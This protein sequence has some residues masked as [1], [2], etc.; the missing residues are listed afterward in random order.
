MNASGT[1]VTAVA[2]ATANI[3]TNAAGTKYVSVGV[4]NAQIAKINVDT[5]TG[6]VTDA[7]TL[8][9]TLQTTIDDGFATTGGS[10]QVTNLHV[11]L[12]NKKVFANIVGANGVGTLNNF[13]LWD[14]TSITGAT[15]FAAGTSLT[16]LSGLKITAAGFT[17]FS[18]ALGLTAIGQ[19]ALA[20]VT[21][22]GTI[23]S[24]IT[25]TAVPEP[26]SYALALAGLAGVGLIARRR[27]V[28]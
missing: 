21:D 14:I 1:V 16:T 19:G 12:T 17:A 13:Y 3:V 8:G 24:S 27:R 22:F 10:L 18:N 20:G 11:D 4:T 7:Y 23:S 28:K 26:S 25:V 6:A 15:H 9:G 5:T 2:P